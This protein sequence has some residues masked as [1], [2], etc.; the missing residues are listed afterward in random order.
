MAK[1][2]SRRKNPAKTTKRTKTGKLKKRK[3]EPK[4]KPVK[5]EERGWA[6]GYVQN[7]V[8]GAIIVIVG[9]LLF[10]RTLSYDLVFCDDNIFVHDFY[11][12]NA[13]ADNIVNSF[14]N[15]LGA[16]YY[17]P[18]LAA[19]FI[20]D[21]QMSEDAKDAYVYRRSNLIFHALGSLLVFL[22]LIR[23]GYNRIG[24]F[25]MGLIY[26]VHP[27]L[28][29]S[30]SWISG[31][32]D[33]MITI[34]IMLSFISLSFF[35]DSKSPL[36][37]ITYIIHL[38]TFALALFTK[39]TAAFFPFVATAYILL[40]RKEKAFTARNFIL[41]G[42]WF[43][44]GLIWFS[45]RENT[46][47]NINTPDTIGLDALIANSPSIL[48]L[49][50]KMFLPLKM[51]ALANLESLTLVAGVVAVLGLGALVAAR[52]KKIDRQTVV[53]AIIWFF[54]FI[55]PTLLIRIQYVGDFFDYAEHRAYLLMFGV[56]I[57]ILEILRTYKVNYTKPVVLIIFGAIVAVLMFRTFIYEPVFENRKT[58]WQNAVD[59][60]PYKSR[61]YL[62][63]GKAYYVS[64]ELDVADSLYHK[65]IELNPDNFNLYIDL[66]A[67]NL[68]RKDYKKAE[69]YARKALKLDPQNPLAH[70]NLAKSMLPRKKYKQSLKHFEIALRRKGQYPQWYLDLGLAYYKTGQ[71]KKAVRAYSKGLS[72]NPKMALGFLNLG[73]AYANLGDFEKAEKAWIKTISLDPKK[74]EAYN[75]LI[76]ISLQKGDAKKALN[77]A[78][79]L[80]KRGG[81]LPGS[82]QR[83]INRIQ[84][85][86]GKM[87]PGFK[88]RR[89]PAN[90]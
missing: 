50:G 86:G 74:Y 77:Y 1:K 81:K 5:K 36:K 31:R 29:P 33:S 18:I 64:N 15:N 65:G 4:P 73:S 7:T 47:S 34:F 35:C 53:F 62:D 12:Y 84:K 71:F 44:V 57:I 13:D 8:Y 32:N 76:S 56:V 37:W 60:Y 49:M 27:I 24:S 85:N 40:F 3:E 45:M 26:M 80:T 43:I 46:L 72:M 20:I 2:Q 66:A 51:H 75:N 16:S 41:A 68:R 88:A 70:Y 83:M 69:S 61:G 6:P 63:L 14:S 38:I 55:L 30:A 78:N 19:S 82:L 59:V 58:Y 90:K 23:F 52:W 21:H 25:L 67:V 28:S 79:L 42:G 17:R 87:P 9:L 89:K 54:V 39:E 48:A 10:S 11:S 22:T